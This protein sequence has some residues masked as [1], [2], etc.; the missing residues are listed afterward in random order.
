VLLPLLLVLLLVVMLL[1]L[2]PELMLLLLALVVV[3]L[4][5]VVV[6][7]VL[8]SWQ[9]QL[10]VGPALQA[11]QVQSLQQRGNNK[12]ST[13]LAELQETQTSTAMPR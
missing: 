5:L 12:P 4:L 13:A 8:L 9:L 1:L 10:Q 6:V 2:V 7:V 3:S 11:Q